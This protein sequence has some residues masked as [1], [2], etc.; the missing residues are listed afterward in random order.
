MGGTAVV[1]QWEEMTNERALKVFLTHSIAELGDIP[2]GMFN[3]IAR[4]QVR[5]RSNPESPLELASLATHFYLVDDPSV[6]DIHLLPL[7]WNWYLESSHLG[8]VKEAAEQ[9]RKWGKPVVLFSAGD[10]T[11]S[12]PCSGLTIFEPCAYRSR[13]FQNGNA[14]FAMPPFIAD[15]VKLYCN[16]ELPL[17]QKGKRPVVG[18]CGLAGGRPHRYAY[19]LFKLRLNWLAYRTG[20]R[21]W[22]PPPFEPSLLRRRVLAQLQRSQDVVSNLL[23][24]GRYRAGYR[25]K[26]KDTFHTT[27]MEY[28]QNMLDSDYIVCMRGGGNFSV[29]FYETLSMGR[30]PI[31]VDTDCLLPYDHIIDYENY[32]PWVKSSEIRNI[33]QI[34]HDFHYSFSADDFRELQVQCRALWVNYLSRDGYWR[35]FHLHFHK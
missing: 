23:I 19:L 11:A 16:G 13:R 29:R 15:F 31:F 20:A 18:F 6:A 9:G 4:A 12:V 32:M 22:E 24:R 21:K 28:V 7:L 26:K 14:V 25:A 33:A 1:S 30:I 8:F 27:R 5:L 35:H 3:D 2:L 34:V 17:R 10:H